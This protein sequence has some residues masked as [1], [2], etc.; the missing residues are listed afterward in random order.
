MADGRT[1][2]QA[3]A[4]EPERQQAVE[5]A[6]AAALERITPETRE[7]RTTAAASGRLLLAAV[8]SWIDG[9]VRRAE[10]ALNEDLR[11]TE[12]DDEVDAAVAAR[13]AG[14]GD[15]PTLVDAMAEVLDAAGAVHGVNAVL[16]QR[17]RDLTGE[18]FR[19][20]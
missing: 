19:A 10:T 20:G 9:D 18:W 8:T 14:A 12:E 6:V 13:L 17:V 11:G 2:D 7:L 16:W 15:P 3:D 5:V 4:G 1:G